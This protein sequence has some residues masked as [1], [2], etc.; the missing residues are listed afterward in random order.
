MYVQYAM[1]YIGLY[2]VDFD[3]SYSTIGGHRYVCEDAQ[4]IVCVCDVCVCMGWRVCE[5]VHIYIYTFCNKL[6]MGKFP[7]V[8]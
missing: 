7:M 2:S 1:Y 6:A 5:T 4:M 8:P 3:I